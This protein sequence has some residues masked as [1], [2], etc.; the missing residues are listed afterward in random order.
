MNNLPKDD[1]KGRAEAVRTL[2]K[3]CRTFQKAKLKTE[4]LSVL[5][6]TLK[7]SLRARPENYMYMII[8]DNSTGRHK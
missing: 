4:C 1:L 3:S 6:N 7:Y 8:I 5:S 2:M